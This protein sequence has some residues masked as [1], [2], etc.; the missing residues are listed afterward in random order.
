MKKFIYLIIFIFVGSVLCMN[1][2][3]DS[4]GLFK[5]KKKSQVN[6]VTQAD[7]T[8]T[9]KDTAI[10]PYKEIIKSDMKTQKGFLTVHSKEDKYYFEIPFSLFGRDILAVNRIA[11]ASV[12]MR[13]GS[14][15]LNGDEIGEC[16]YQWTKGYDNK[17]YLK[18]ISFTEYAKDSTSQMYANVIANNVQ[19]IAE[20]F[21]ILAYNSDSTAAVI[22]VTKFLGSDNNVLYF[23]NQP[24]KDRA[25]LGSQEDEKSYIQYVH[26]YPTNLEVR[27]VKT[28]KA[29]KNPT[30][31]NYTVELNS[32]LVLLPEKPMKPRLED[33]R[34]GYFTV[35]FR[36]FDAN[37]QG[38][39]ITKY[40]AR[41][42]LE[43]KPEDIDKY[44]RGELVEPKKPIVFYIDPTTP[45][46]WIP[47]LIQ[48]VNDWQKAFE[49]AGFK[50][51]I[52]GRMA[53]IA[54]E[55]STWSM[56][57][58]MYSAIIYRPSEI[59]NAMG[60]HVAD[61]RSG[62]IIE[63]HI[64]WY[65]NVMS[66]LKQWYM[67]QCGTI[68]KRARKPEIDDKLMGELIRF[69]SSHEVGHTLGLRH[70]FGSSSTVPVDKLR[71]KEWLKKYG[72]TPSIMDYARFN[73]VAQP[74]DNVGLAGLFPRINDYDKWAIYW[75]YKWMPDSVDIKS[76]ERRLGKIVTDTLKVNH[77]LWFGG[78]TEPFD[79]R[80]QNE[81]LGDDA[82]KA[83]EYGIKNLKRIVPQLAEWY[84]E[85]DKDY[86]D[87]GKAFSEV[88]G[89]YNR[90]I[91]H[92]MKNIGGIYHNDLRG[93]DQKPLYARTEYL[94]QK[95]AVEFLNNQ[96][97]E[98]P[99][100]LNVKDI[101]DKMPYSFGIELNNLQKDVVFAIL[102]RT[103][104]STLLNNQYEFKGKEYGLDELFHDLDRGILKEIY[105]G[106][107]ISFYRRNLQNIYIYRLIEEAY[108]QENPGL[109]NGYAV[110]PHF[111]SD[112]QG[113]IVTELKY[114]KSIIDKVLRRSNL[115]KATRIH[116]QSLS[117]RIKSNLNSIVIRKESL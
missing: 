75:G 64:F 54:Q 50:N 11:K 40:V 58:A 113:A 29:G 16:V 19:A 68:D 74:E 52:Y 109:V 31:P 51:A 37:P 102:S 94:K 88:F 26:S 62:E 71:D 17:I 23:E 25:G 82:M 78:E 41:W 95:R 13:N 8:K 72:H 27:A 24:L 76:V 45:K 98:T 39:D 114:Q 90:Y 1:A 81:D 67:V 77:R 56:D 106:S 112:M 57:N 3:A 99:E 104:M 69:V 97:F 21:P 89:Q 46:K 9:H 116:L 2:L 34:V 15:G 42:R 18:R 80:C 53:P 108:A 61:P 36:D 84:V 43:P 33:S 91:G 101:F 7:S 100:W 63:S 38:V 47:Y 49:V 111:L 103:R 48:G 110:Y 93:I 96:L 35:G 83:S 28:Y 60:P 65:H 22:D 73:Y 10:K 20:S 79:P 117:E 14:W 107:N 6:K 59:A 66:V 30:W 115:N 105:V 32:S 12:D 44:L 92:V 87:L 4:Q 85:P 70:N 86:T 55:D 5:K